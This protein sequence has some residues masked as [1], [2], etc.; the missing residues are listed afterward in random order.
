MEAKTPYF[1]ESRDS[2]LSF[3][4]DQFSDKERGEMFE[5]FSQKLL[6]QDHFSAFETS[7]IV[8]PKIEEIEKSSPTEKTGDKGIDIKCYDV[9]NQL[10][11]ICQV[12]F[13]IR[14]KS[15]IDGIISAFEAYEKQCCDKDNDASAKTEKSS[16]ELFDTSQYDKKTSKSAK[17]IMYLCMT[18]SSLHR[19]KQQRGDGLLERYRKSGLSSCQF[20][21]KLYEE[22]RIFFI[23]GEDILRILKTSFTKLVGK[24]PSFTLELKDNP[25]H[26]KGV[27]IGLVSGYKLK[28]LYSDFGESIFFE[29]IRLFLGKEK[30]DKKAGGETVN[31]GI[32]RTVREEPEAMLSRNN[33][34]TFKASKVE[35]EGSNLALEEASIINGCQTTMCFV[36]GLRAQDESHAEPLVLV[37]VV[38]TNDSWDIAESAN[39]Q[40]EVVQLD[41]KLARYLRPQLTMNMG[42]SQG[43]YA[44]F[45]TGNSTPYEILAAM[46]KM[47][48]DYE[49][50]KSTF[51]GLF[52]KVPNSAIA[53]D[54]KSLRLNLLE[55][56]LKQDESGEKTFQLISE[57]TSRLEE[58]YNHF[59]QA[60][61]EK[62]TSSDLWTRL[63]GNPGYSPF[64]NI[65]VM[66]VVSDENIYDNESVSIE[67]VWRILE[68]VCKGNDSRVKVCYRECFKALTSAIDQGRERE[69]NQTDLYGKIR[70]MG[71]KK[72]FSNLFT[73]ALTFVKMEEIS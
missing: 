11:A 64:F 8:I 49:E 1:L 27:Y 68:G 63:G 53:G 44:D 9:H 17:R 29:N 56:F 34:I 16:L 36:K 30:G 22:N 45:K 13:Q 62:T 59:S 6:S 32:L 3:F 65:L 33:G 55:D 28:K 38:E 19:Q 54:Y 2:L 46:T 26:Y 39:F 40:N 72:G 70:N 7:G 48:V 10:V 41:L 20:Y 37:K 67:N 24:L 21:Q 43:I 51:A 31:Q 35:A 23:D 50:I 42:I 25:I 61:G 71:S 52:S 58:H 15:E 5:N 14:E 57:A 66:C 47:K 60:F 18:M 73:S 69:R 4:S 12:K